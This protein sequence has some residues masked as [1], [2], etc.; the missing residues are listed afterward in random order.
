MVASL[1]LANVGWAVMEGIS[2]WA[3]PHSVQCAAAAGIPAP[4]NPQNLWKPPADPETGASMVGEVS[5]SCGSSGCCAPQLGQALDP[6]GSSDPQNPQNCPRTVKAH[7]L[8]K[9]N[10]SPIQDK[11]FQ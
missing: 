9:H 5:S 11:S 8:A 4:Q 6:R 1:G 10:D 7:F 2:G 3:W